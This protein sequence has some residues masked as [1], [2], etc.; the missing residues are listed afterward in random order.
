M[1]PLQRLAQKKHPLQL[2]NK[3]EKVEPKVPKE[4]K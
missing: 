4:V 1:D 3:T 2:P